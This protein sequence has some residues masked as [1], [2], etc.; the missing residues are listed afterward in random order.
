[1][2]RINEAKLPKEEQDA[3]V[4]A[5]NDLIHQVHP[6]EKPIIIRLPPGQKGP[7]KALTQEYVDAWNSIIAAY[8]NDNTT[9]LELQQ[10]EQD[11]LSGKIKSL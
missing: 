1:M 2:E 6:E 9:L 7:K 8:D 4:D 5:I 10:L 11:I 3:I